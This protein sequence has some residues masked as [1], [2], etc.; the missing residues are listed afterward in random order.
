MQPVR[1]KS[2]EEITHKGRQDINYDNA[3]KISME[4]QVE[5]T[6]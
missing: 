5:H 4:I 3:R 2:N 1:Q 6:V